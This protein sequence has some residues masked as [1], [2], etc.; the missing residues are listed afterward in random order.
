M[1]RTR[2]GNPILA[3]DASTTVRD[4]LSL[5]ARAEAASS[6]ENVRTPPVDGDAVWADEGHIGMQAADRVHRQRSRRAERGRAQLAPDH[7]DLYAGA[8]GEQL[9]DVQGAG[10][11][12]QMTV[13]EA[14]RQSVGGR[15]VGEKERHAILDE[16]HG[17]LGNEPLLAPVATLANLE[18]LFEGRVT[19]NR[20]SA[21]SGARQQPEALEQHEVAARRCLAGSGHLHDIRQRRHGL[22]SQQLLHAS[23]AFL[24]QDASGTGRLSALLHGWR[25]PPFVSETVSERSTSV[26]DIIDLTEI[27]MNTRRT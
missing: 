1:T 8:A 23:P 21:T 10:D 4:E 3:G 7:D 14:L 12:R 27:D 26:K 17:P 22:T 16:P 18:L 24:C 11:D 2:A 19:L 13:D 6:R 20:P 5:I 25:P 9:S 15:A